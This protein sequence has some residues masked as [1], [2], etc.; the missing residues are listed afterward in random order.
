[1]V[2]KP[3]AN[4]F[5]DAVGEGDELLQGLVAA[6][7][8]TPGVRWS[9]PVTLFV[10]GTIVSGYA[11]RFRDYLQGVADQFKAGTADDEEG[12]ALLAVFDQVFRNAS[13]EAGQPDSE[14]S[15]APAFIHL[16]KARVFTGQPLEGAGVMWRGRLDAVDGF[17]FG[18]MEAQR[19]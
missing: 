11:I 16:E 4:G 6:L 1:M 13:E 3:E 9:F 17:C 18:I 12:E 19:S 2:Q 8:S 15:E 14:P 5:V 10:G 7:E